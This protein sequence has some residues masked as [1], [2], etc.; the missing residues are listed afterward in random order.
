MD[1]F[2]RQLPPLH[3]DGDDGEVV[4]VWR[5]RWAGGPGR[6]I[7][8]EPELDFLDEPVG[9]GFPNRQRDV[10]KVQI[11]LDRAG[12]IDLGRSGGPTGRFDRNLGRAV[13]GYQE[14]RGLEVD[15]LLEP[16]G[17]TYRSL[18]ADAAGG[19]ADGLRSPARPS[20]S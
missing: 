17:P 8:D 3:H 19:G 18:L 7:G 14:R 2:A 1:P 20:A 11:L 4:A 15:G 12:E 13:R 9:A 5:D 10:A 6:L 16:G